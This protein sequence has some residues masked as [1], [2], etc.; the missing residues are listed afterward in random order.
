V[1]TRSALAWAGVD[2]PVD[3]HGLRHKGDV[4]TGLA[5]ATF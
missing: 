3:V 4:D 1:F 2:E 5:G